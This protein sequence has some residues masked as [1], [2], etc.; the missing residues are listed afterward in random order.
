MTR[1]Q[2][3][4]LVEGSEISGYLRASLSDEL[5]LPRNLPIAGGG[6]DNA[7]TAIG[8]GVVRAGD[9]FV[10]LGTSGVLLPLVTAMLLRRKRRFTHSPMLLRD[11]GTRWG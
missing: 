1:A 6:G 5:G 8:M 11:A 10:S 2:M 4:R 7:A 3:P 9:A